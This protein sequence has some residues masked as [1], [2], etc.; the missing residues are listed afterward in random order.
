MNSEIQ[1]KELELAKRR[2]KKSWFIEPS[3]N[4]NLWM[5]LF[6]MGA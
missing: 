2:K 1:P 6:A 5:C 4:N 3:G